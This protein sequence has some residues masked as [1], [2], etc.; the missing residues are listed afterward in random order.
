ME[1]RRNTNGRSMGE[2]SELS[3]P[4]GLSETEESTFSILMRNKLNQA[5]GATSVALQTKNGQFTCEYISEN[6]NNGE[7]MR[8]ND[9]SEPNSGPQSAPAKQTTRPTKT[10]HDHPNRPDAKGKQSAHDDLKTYIPSLEIPMTKRC[11]DKWA[12]FYNKLSEGDC[13]DILLVLSTPHQK[14]PEHN[15]INKQWNSIFE[16]LTVDDRFQLYDRLLQVQQRMHNVDPDWMPH[17][18]KLNLQL[19][20]AKQKYQ[21][22]LSKLRMLSAAAKQNKK[23]N[24]RNAVKKLNDTARKQTISESSMSTNQ[25]IANNKPKIR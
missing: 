14:M 16:R 2:P 3:M 13:T 25:S 21:S 10:I 18:T 22:Q 4:L 7:T 19:L 12:L 23:A 20:A 5:N 6:I 9:I 1:S 24:I 8:T 11:C 17:R 15:L